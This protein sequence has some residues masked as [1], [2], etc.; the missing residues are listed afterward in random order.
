MILLSPCNSYPGSQEKVTESPGSR[1]SPLRLPFMGIPGSLQAV[2][3]EPE[4]QTGSCDSRIQRTSACNVQGINEHKRAQTYK[5]SFIS[6]VDSCHAETVAQTVL[7]H[8]ADY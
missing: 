4:G 3:S 7:Q 2:A 1:P 5:H 8:R 6:M